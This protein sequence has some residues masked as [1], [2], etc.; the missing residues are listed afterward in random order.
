MAPG[1]GFLHYSYCVTSPLPTRRHG[2]A[3]RRE[4]WTP[5]N[6]PPASVWRYVQRA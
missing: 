2:L 1:R 5:L 3:G 4:A 6:L